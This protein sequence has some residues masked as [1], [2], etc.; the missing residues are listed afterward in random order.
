MS[1]RQPQVKGAKGKKVPTTSVGEKLSAVVQSVRSYSY[2]AYNTAWQTC[3]GAKISGT[4][5]RNGTGLAGITVALSTGPTKTTGNDGSYKFGFLTVGVNYTVTPQSA[6]HDFVPASIDVHP[7]TVNRTDVD[8]AATAMFTVSGRITKDNVATDGITVRAGTHTAV[9]ANGGRYAFRLP[10]GS[11]YTIVPTVPHCTLDHANR[12]TGM[13]NGDLADQDFAATVDRYSISGKV[14]SPVDVEVVLSGGKSETKKVRRG[15]TFSF[16]SL[17]GGKDYTLKVNAIEHHT[18]KP[19][20]YELKALSANTP[21]QDFA[22][23]VKTY[24]ICGIV[25]RSGHGLG[26]VLVKLEGA[27]KGPKTTDHNG[28]YNF[29]SLPA[30]QEYTVTPEL[31]YH[32]FKPPFTTFRLKGK[33]NDADFAATWQ[34]FRVGGKIAYANDGAHKVTVKL[35]GAGEHT[36]DTAADGKYE[37]QGIHGGKK[38]KLTPTGGH[39]T[40]N[41]TSLDVTVDGDKLNNNF[42]GSWNRWTIDGVVTMTGTGAVR[43]KVPIVLDDGDTA[44]TSTDA[45]GAYA[46]TADAGADYNVKPDL[47]PWTFAPSSLDITPL[48]GNTTQNFVAT[49]K[50]HK[51]TEARNPLTTTYGMD[52]LTCSRCS[53]SPLDHPESP[54]RETQASYDACMEIFEIIKEMAEAEKKTDDEDEDTSEDENGKYQTMVG[55]LLCTNGVKYAAHSGSDFRPKGWKKKTISGYRLA[56]GLDDPVNA[57]VGRSGNTLPALSKDSMSNDVGRCAA[58]KLVQRANREGNRPLAMTEI[59]YRPGKA[60]HGKTITS[61]KTCQQTVPLMLCDR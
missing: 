33:K 10:G 20:Q 15:N 31:A 42:K 34:T 45:N 46:F 25:Q 32:D 59:W 30:L 43:S 4:I 44:S 41:P 54:I 16:K 35:T 51:A 2:S 39:H 8:F 9:T 1:R 40:P 50:I 11:A 27:E 49:A 18:A 21:N 61:C 17:E 28:F 58:Q 14:T 48:A 3:L 22:V 36:A 57:S 55:V 52:L 53:R 26:G 23:T 6:G 60:E 38:V 19:G 29:E 24:D 7:L 56:F 13:L 47:P 37:F 5:T 12:N